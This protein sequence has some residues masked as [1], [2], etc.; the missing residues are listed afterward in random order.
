MG[1]NIVEEFN[2]DYEE[3]NCMCDKCHKVSGTEEL[4]ECPYSQELYG[5]DEPSCNCCGACTQQCC[6]DI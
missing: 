5:D 6:D 1:R 3:I 4:H 2:M